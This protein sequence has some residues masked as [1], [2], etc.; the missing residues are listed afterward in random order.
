[1]NSRRKGPNRIMTKSVV[2]MLKSEIGKRENLSQ[3]LV[4]I[5]RGNL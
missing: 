2:A 3:M 1:M 5:E 4:T